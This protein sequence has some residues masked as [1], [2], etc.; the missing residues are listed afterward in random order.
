MHKNR[1]A[2]L[3]DPVFCMIEKEKMQK[4][5]ECLLTAGDGFDIIIVL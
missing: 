2:F 3:A 4:C 5:R 1:D